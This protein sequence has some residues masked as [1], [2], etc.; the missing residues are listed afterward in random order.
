M[1]HQKSDIRPGEI[2]LG[3]QRF[4]IGDYVE[5]LGTHLEISDF[6]NNID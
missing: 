1:H 2:I 3:D 4:L 6:T 5:I